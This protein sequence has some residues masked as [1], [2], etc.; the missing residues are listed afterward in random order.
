MSANITNRVR[1]NGDVDA[2]FDVW[3]LDIIIML[4]DTFLIKRGVRIR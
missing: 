3:R 4:K 1:I 2:P